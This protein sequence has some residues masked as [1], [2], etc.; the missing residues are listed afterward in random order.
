MMIEIQIAVI[1]ECIPIDRKHEVAYLV[2]EILT[3]I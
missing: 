3:L 2:L 1:R